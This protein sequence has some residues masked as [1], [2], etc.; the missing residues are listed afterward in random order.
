MLHF[1]EPTLAETVDKSP[2][3][4][5]SYSLS[6]EAMSPLEVSQSRSLALH[7]VVTS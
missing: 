1:R 7:F 4:N 6:L 2:R 3:I 5:Y